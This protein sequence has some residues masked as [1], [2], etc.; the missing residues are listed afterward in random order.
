[1][2]QANIKIRSSYIGGKMEIPQLSL[3]TINDNSMCLGC[4][5][6]NQHGFK[7]KFVVEADN[8][9]AEFTPKE[10]HQ[11]WPGFTH[12]GALMIVLDEAIGW[13]TFVKN[14]YAVTAKIEIRIRSMARIGEP[15][16]VTAFVKKQTSRTLEVEANIKRQDGSVVAEASSLQ[17]ITRIA[18]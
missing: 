9:S 14:I 11:G 5:K 7:L 17:F 6:S 12:G 2:I 8:V 15:L 16:T 3:Q 4:G 10:H 18:P 1:M 13:A